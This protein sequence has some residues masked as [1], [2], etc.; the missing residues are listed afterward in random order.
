MPSF[1]SSTPRA[2]LFA[3]MLLLAHSALGENA[4]IDPLDQPAAVERQLSQKP[5][6]DIARA[7]KRLVA[8]GSNGLI[9]FS[10]DQGQSWVQA[11]V[12]VSVDL[13]AV[14]FA[15]ATQG[16]A[17]GHGATI[18]HSSDAGATWTKQLD[19]RALQALFVDYFNNRSGLAQESANSYLSAILDMTRPGTGQFFMGVWFDRAGNGFVVGPFGLLLG[20]GDGGKSWQPWNTRIDNNDLLHLTSIREVAGTLLVTGERGRVWRLDP[21]TKRF[22]SSETGYQGTLFG[23]TGV[24][25]GLLAFGLRGHVFRSTDAGHSWT[26][27]KS[28]FNAGITAGIALDNQRLVL[29]SQSAQAGISRDGGLSFNLLD[30]QQPSL[31]TGVIGLAGER[32]ALVGLNGVTI[33]AAN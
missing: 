18:L 26:S 22:E 28:E 14:F 1:I 5:L 2:L 24:P 29:V 27:V 4:F 21:A 9:I 31:F 11:P 13:N 19:G 17:V 15:D 8:V 23:V 12:P 3:V 30:V 25:G 10:D 16:W 6:R 20:S 7:G 32:I 33:M